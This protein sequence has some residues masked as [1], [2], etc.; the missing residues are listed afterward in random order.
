VGIEEAIV[1]SVATLQL[2]PLCKAAKENKIEN[3]E[4]NTGSE[5]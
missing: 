1:E 4:S 5:V 2:L 3:Q